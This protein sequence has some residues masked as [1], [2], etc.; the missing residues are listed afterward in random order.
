MFYKNYVQAS[1]NK[2]EYAKKKNAFRF[3]GTA[4]SMNTA[5]CTY[6]LYDVALLY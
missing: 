2:R 6:V 1:T 3:C 4:I 5:V